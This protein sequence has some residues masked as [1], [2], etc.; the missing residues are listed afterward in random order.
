M[1][2]VATPEVTNSFGKEGHRNI[3]DVEAQIS[4]SYQFGCSSEL[5]EW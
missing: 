2:W 1:K 3:S 4:G 5:Q